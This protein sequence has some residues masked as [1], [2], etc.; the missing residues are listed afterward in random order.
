M[1]TVFY[2]LAVSK[3]RIFCLGTRRRPGWR[4]KSWTLLAEAKALEM[5]TGSEYS[6]RGPTSRNGNPTRALLQSY[7]TD[8]NE[9]EGY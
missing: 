8:F 1:N 9:E 2:K 5:E 6:G 4:L 3:P 7:S